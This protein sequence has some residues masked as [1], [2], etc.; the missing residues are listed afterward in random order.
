GPYPGQAV[1]GPGSQPNPYNNSGASNYNEVGDG[2]GFAASAF[3]EKSIRHAFIRKVYLILTAQLLVTVAFICLLL[4][5]NPVRYWV[6]RNSWFYYISYGVFL[7]TYISLICCPSVRRRF[8]G[9]FI[10]LAIFTLAFSYMTGTIASFHRT[11]SVLIAAGI[12]AALCLAITLFATQTRIDFTMCSAMLFVL[13]IV[14]FI[15]GIVCAIVYAVSGPNRVLQAVYGGLGALLFGLY[16]AYDTQ[17]IMG[18]RKHEM[19]P[20]EY[21]FG[22]LQ[23]YLDVVYLFL[24]ILSLFGNKE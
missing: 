7:C 13:T 12:T 5:V 23:L 21:I 9:N 14:V 4:L 1:Y 15:T 10:A 11:E 2:S 22:A 24:M 20:E 17:M 8:P 19:S 6:L 18:G 16:L 3:S